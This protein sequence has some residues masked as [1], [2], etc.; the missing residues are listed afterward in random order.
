MTFW[1]STLTSGTFVLNSSDGASF[2]SIQTDV[3]A[4]QCTVTGG[5][6]F[7]GLPSTP[8]GLSLGQGLNFSSASSASSLNGITITWI[9]GTIDIVV[10]F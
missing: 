10:G 4:G 7:K 8:V 3:V 5:I 6:P 1:T 9:A 2:I